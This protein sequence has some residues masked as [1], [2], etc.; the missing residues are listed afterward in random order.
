VGNA[1]K[2]ELAYSIGDA[3]WTTVQLENTTITLV[4]LLP[5]TAYAVRIRSICDD[6]ASSWTD[7]N[8]STTE[9]VC[10]VPTNLQATGI[11]E[12]SALLSWNAD[13]ENVTWNLRHREGA[14]TSWTTVNNLTEKSYLFEN[15]TDNTVYFWSV[16]GACN[17]D[18]TSAWATQGTFTTLERVGI[19]NISTDN[20]NVFVSNRII[21]IVNAKSILIDR[22]QLY[23]VNGSLLKEFIVNSADNILIPT[24]VNQSIALVKVF[25]K[26]ASSTFKILIK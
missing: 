19:D 7:A 6:D 24:A 23:D 13:E 20:L 18:L 10:I 17:G 5:Q 8:F 9:I 15:L 16:R 22:I 1:A 26:N 3:S 2:Y 25:S 11:S 21:N 4:D 14:I 12:V